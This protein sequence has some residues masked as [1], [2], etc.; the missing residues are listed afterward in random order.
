MK[1]EKSAD[2]KVL[3]SL[4][5]EAKIGD[6]ITYEAMSKALGRDVR[7]FAIN[8][9]RS[10]R[11]AMLRDKKFVFSVEDNVGLVRL[12]DSEIVKS[13][14]LDRHRIS[15]IAKRTLNKLAVVAFDGLDDASK[16]TH[17]VFSAQ[18][19]A[20]AMFASKASVNK[21]ESKVSSSSKT[22]AIGET[23]KMFTE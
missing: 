9:L 19:G 5:S 8:A 13:S 14:G 12:N 15:R 22:L 10:A 17:V 11:Y 21:I 23:L 7:K 20:I 2:T 16:K 6:T 3:E 18:M 4:F 1:F